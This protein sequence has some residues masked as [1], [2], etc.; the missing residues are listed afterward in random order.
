MTDAETESFFET[1]DAHPHGVYLVTIYPEERNAVFTTKSA[2][3]AWI[4][5]LPDYGQSLTI[6]YVLDEP[7]FGNVPVGTLQ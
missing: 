6:P 7:D 2:A 1:H 4:R 3:D 5:S